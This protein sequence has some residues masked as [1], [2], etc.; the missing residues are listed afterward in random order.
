MPYILDYVINKLTNKQSDL[1][2]PPKASREII[3]IQNPRLAQLV[4]NALV[5]PPVND[6]TV[7]VFDTTTRADSA[8]I[9]LTNS[10]GSNRYIF[11]VSMLGKLVLRFGAGEEG[12]EGFVHD[13]FVDEESISKSGIEELKIANRFI[14][15]KAQVEKIADY[16]WKNNRVVKHVYVVTFSGSRYWFEPG[17]WYTLQIGGVGQK[18]YIDSKVRCE[19]ISIEKTSDEIG[20]TILTLVEVEQNWV[21]NTS[22]LARFIAAGSLEREGL[23]NIVRVAASDSSGKADFYC[24]GTADE[25]QI[26]AAIDW[27]QTLG[28]KVILSEGTFVTAATITMRSKV[29][30][31]GAG[32]D[33]TI[34]EKNGAFAGITIGVDEDNYEEYLIIRDLQVTRNSSDTETNSLIRVHGL[35]NGRFE[36]VRFKDS[37]RYGLH[38]EGHCQRIRITNCIVD[39]SRSASIR[40]S[41][42][43]DVDQFTKDIQIDGSQIINN[44]DITNATAAD[45]ISVGEVE[46]VQISN[47]LIAENTGWGIRTL[48]CNNALIQNNHIRGNGTSLTGDGGIEIDQSAANTSN[49]NAVL[50]NLIVENYKVGINLEA[51]PGTPNTDGTQI[52]GNNAV[53]NGVGNMLDHENCEAAGADHPHIAFDGSSLVLATVARD[54]TEAK[55]G[56]Y[57]RKITTTDDTFEAVFRVTDDFSTGDMHEVIAGETYRGRVWVYIP[58]AGGPAAAS[59]VVLKIYWWTGAAWDTTTTAAS[60]KDAWEQLEVETAVGAGATGFSFQLWV[61][62]GAIG[63]Y[64]YFDDIELRHMGINNIEGNLEVQ[65]QVTNSPTNTKETDNSWQ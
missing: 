65:F 4:S 61:S 38:I 45:G 24:D 9:L 57:S 62:P 63:Q 17:E 55:T 25:V 1:Y 37:Y 21:F 32:P 10:T 52:R 23:G 26:Q 49:F 6:L 43:A 56:T 7:T 46:N 48:D 20:L 31:E 51:D 18:E 33:A 39:G 64:I 28:G 15:D 34:I 59:D 5:G 8:R 42:D 19:G 36:N 2:K 60:V 30:L 14:I 44:G 47:C 54:A 12:D 16:H 22:A 35:I 11:N 41:I 40:L 29:F 58:S 3:G 50:N 13:S 53:A 27:V